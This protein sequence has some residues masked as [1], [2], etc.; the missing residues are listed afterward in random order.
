MLKKPKV[1]RRKGHQIYIFSIRKRHKIIQEE[2]TDKGDKPLCHIPSKGVVDDNAS[3]CLR[4]REIITE[5]SS[6]N[7]DIHKLCALMQRYCVILLNSS[8]FELAVSLATSNAAEANEACLL[9]P[10][11]N[12]LP[13]LPETG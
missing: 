12:Y 8:S 7:H 9:E 5:S 1:W 2:K 11:C 10:T 13:G 4:S 6:A 3:S